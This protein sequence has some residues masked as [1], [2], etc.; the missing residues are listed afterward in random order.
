MATE[1]DPAA[2]VAGIDVPDFGRHCDVAAQLHV[3]ADT[4]TMLT[5]DMERVFRVISDQAAQRADLEAAVDEAQAAVERAEKHR[6]STA[7][8]AE[9]LGAMADRRREAHLVAR[10]RL[11]VFNRDSWAARI[12][13]LEDAKART[14]GNLHVPLTGT[15]QGPLMQRVLKQGHGGTPADICRL[16]QDAMADFAIVVNDLARKATPHDGNTGAVE[17]HAKW[18]AAALLT[19]PASQI[20]ADLAQAAIS[21]REIGVSGAGDTA[22]TT[23]T[24]FQD[25]FNR[26]QA[27]STVPKAVQRRLP[28]AAYSESVVGAPIA[29]GDLLPPAKH[30]ATCRLSARSSEALAAMFKAELDVVRGRLHALMVGGEEHQQ[31]PPQSVATGGRMLRRAVRK[32][33]PSQ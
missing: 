7:A 26:A 31:L 27:C 24:T 19:Q 1:R 23:T 15:F 22:T 30:V 32:Q 14:R 12:Q 9:S 2:T 17:L 6:G 33:A 20:S 11:A 3:L 28:I 4:L 8:D 21:L 10:D 13:R 18:S 29:A 16:R 5:R 25:T